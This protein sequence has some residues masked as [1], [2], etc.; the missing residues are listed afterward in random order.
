MKLFSCRSSRY[1]AE[2]I[3]SKL[4]IEVGKSSVTNF[5]DGEFQPCFDE[6]VR[7][8]MVFIV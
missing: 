8:C 6:S 1:L 2:Q 3:A 4:G 7:G 5:S